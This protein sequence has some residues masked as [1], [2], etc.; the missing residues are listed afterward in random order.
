MRRKLIVLGV[1]LAATTLVFAGDKKKRSRYPQPAGAQVVATQENLKA[2][3]TQLVVQEQAQMDRDYPR[4]PEWQNCTTFDV[5]ADADFVVRARPHVDKR[6]PD[7][8]AKIARLEE[9]WQNHLLKHQLIRQRL[10][11]PH[12]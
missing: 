8:N 11:R 5:I 4:V 1:L 2:V 9:Q 3:S 6:D 12:E 7:Y 10:G